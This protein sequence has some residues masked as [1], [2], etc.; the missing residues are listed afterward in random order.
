M[1]L[2]GEGGSLTTWYGWIPIL[3]GKL[4]L[5]KEEDIE[6]R[7]RK[8]QEEIKDQY[9]YDIEYTHES[10]DKWELTLRTERGGEFQFEVKLKDNGLIRIEPTGG[11]PPYDVVLTIYRF[12]RD[13]YHEHIHHS[14]DLLLLPVEASTENDAVEGILDQYRRK[15]VFYHRI[16]KDLIDLRRYDDAKEL[17]LAGR[18]EMQYAKAFITLFTTGQRKEDLIRIFE[19]SDTSLEVLMEKVNTYSSWRETLW[20]GAFSAV[21][22]AFFIFLT[23]LDTLSGLNFEWQLDLPFRSIFLCSLLS[24][25]SVIVFWIGLLIF[26][27]GRR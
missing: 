14:G 2:W 21:V 4:F 17:I 8:L 5:E 13:V 3:S 16:A 19:N 9:D 26:R 23:E 6:K 1:K 7:A 12:I 20:R 15:V 11:D 10:R 24:A 27:R 25:I 18:G 22:T